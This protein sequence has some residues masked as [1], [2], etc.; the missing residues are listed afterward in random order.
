MSNRQSLEP[1]GP[2]AKAFKPRMTHAFSHESEGNVETVAREALHFPGRA[3]RPLDD[4][5]TFVHRFGEAEFAQLR[6]ILDAVEIDMGDEKRRTLIGL[7]EC[8]GRRG[9]V[10]GKAVLAKVRLHEGAG[11]R[12]LAGAEIAPEQDP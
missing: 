4:D 9:N 8:E 7:D 2:A 11:E 6:W 12:G 3:L 1:R 5:D 10:V